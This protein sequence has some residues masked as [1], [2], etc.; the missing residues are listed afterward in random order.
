VR[1]YFE[2]RAPL[3][4]EGFDD[5]MLV[6]RTGRRAKPED[7]LTFIEDAQTVARQFER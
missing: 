1:A 7:V 6:Y 3:T 2:Q 5:G 4:V